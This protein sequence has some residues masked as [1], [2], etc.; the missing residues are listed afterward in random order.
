MEEALFELI[1]RTRN[2][3]EQ[4]GIFPTH[5]LRSEIGKEID[6]SLNELYIKGKISVGDTLNSKWISVK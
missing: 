6:K 5:I 3:K 2:E 1:V 4:S